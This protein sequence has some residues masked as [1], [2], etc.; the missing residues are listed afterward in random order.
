[1]EIDPLDAIEVHRDGG[2]VAGETHT[3]TVGRNIDPLGDIGAVEHQRVEAGLTLDRVAAVAGVPDEGV[4]AGAEESHVVARSADDEIVVLA[5]EDRVVADATIDDRVIA[6]ATTAEASIV[7]L[8]AP[9]LMVSWS[10]AS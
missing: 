4:V 6:P 9:P 5:A 2:D 8:P 3:P 10:V 7:S 1:V